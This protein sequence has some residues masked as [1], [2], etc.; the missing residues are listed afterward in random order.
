MTNEQLKKIC[1][2]LRNNDPKLVSLNLD[3]ENLGVDGAL[4]LAEA[5]HENKIVNSVVIYHSKLGFRGTEAILKALK[6]RGIKTQLQVCDD[7][8]EEEYNTLLSMTPGKGKSKRKMQKTLKD[9]SQK[10]KG[11]C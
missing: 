3:Y 5:L 2:R 7:F 9:A 6:G 4:L 1:D 8:T 11:K 10:S